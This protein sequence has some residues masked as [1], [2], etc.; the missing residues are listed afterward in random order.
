MPARQPFTSLCRSLAGVRRSARVDLHIHTV[1]SDGLYT[2]AQI[3]ELAR[4]SGLPAVAI[5]DHDTLAAIPIARELAGPDLEIIPGVEIS[6]VH[7]GRELH[8]L[9]YFVEPGHGP[10]HE[11]LEHLQHHRRTRF[12]AM[13][14]RLRTLGVPLADAV[15]QSAAA[16]GAMGRRHL[17]NLL[18]A[19]RKASSVREAFQR[20]LGDGGRVN[21]LK[22]RLPTGEAIALVR[23]A[24]GVSSWAHPGAD[25]TWEVVRELYNS[26]MRALEVDW[27]TVKPGRARELRAWACELR[28]AV[29]GGSDCHGPDEPRRSVGICGITV[30]ELDKLRTFAECTVSRAP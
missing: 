28:M 21:V 20:Y 2:P 29:T 7:R 4:R 15:L 27:P 3:V 24:G 23:A 22:E 16:Q 13:A 9:A 19:E 5:T 30:E 17:A 26:G 6:T 18:V 25:C 14:D 11:A 8:L 1:W 12:F 10:L